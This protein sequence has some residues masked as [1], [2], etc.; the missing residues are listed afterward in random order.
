MSIIELFH[1]KTTHLDKNRVI[2][3]LPITDNTKQ[4]YGLVHG[5]I[6]ALL[7]ETAASLGANANLPSDKIAVGVDIQTHHLR[8]VTDGSLIATATP[9]K[10]G[11][12][13]QIWQ[14]TTTNDAH[15]TSFSTIT[16][17]VQVKP[18]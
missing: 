12:T 9:I 17:A 13:L 11:R 6:N 2:I 16:L 7:A 5:G 18:Q 1:M 15:E 8:P 14:V 4:P 3:E 10:I